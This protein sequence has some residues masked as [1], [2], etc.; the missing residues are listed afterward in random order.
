MLSRIVLPRRFNNNRGADIFVRPSN[1][2]FPLRLL[3]LFVLPLVV[4]VADDDEYK[5]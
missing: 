5:V 3:L 4:V 1:R 2:T